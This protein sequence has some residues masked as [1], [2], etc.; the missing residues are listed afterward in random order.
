M[1]L[2]EALREWE[3]FSNE[4]NI[5][6]GSS[7]VLVPVAMR[8]HTETGLPWVIPSLS[9]GGEIILEMNNIKLMNSSDSTLEL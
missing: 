1:V 4:Q 9:F 3:Q 2:Q 6:L 7:G 5:S 8:A